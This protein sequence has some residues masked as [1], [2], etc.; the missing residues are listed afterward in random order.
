VGQQNG[1][2]ISWRHLLPFGG[3]PILFEA[4]DLHG[5]NLGFGLVPE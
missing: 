2:Y 1:A 4:C 5:L 3:G